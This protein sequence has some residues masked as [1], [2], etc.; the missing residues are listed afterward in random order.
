MVND[1]G[2]WY[3]RI[4]FPDVFAFAGYFCSD[5]GYVDNGRHTSEVLHQHSGRRVRN[6]FFALGL[7]P[8]QKRFQVLLGDSK[9][10][11]V[12]DGV[13]KQNTDRVGQFRYSGVLLAQVPQIVIFVC[14]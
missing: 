11:V 7:F 2:S 10:V 9:S 6:F 13:F 3:E 14:A 12:T 4:G 5:R 1:H 8:V